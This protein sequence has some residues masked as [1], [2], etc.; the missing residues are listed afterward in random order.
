MIIDQSIFSSV[1]ILFNSHNHFSWQHM[2]IAERKLMLVKKWEGKALGPRGEVGETKC[3]EIEQS[4]ITGN[5]FM[6]TV[7]NIE[8]CVVMT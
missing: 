4:V 6:I 3:T 7:T 5:R 1:I 2:D 8:T